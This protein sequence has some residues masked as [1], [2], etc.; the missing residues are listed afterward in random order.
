MNVLPPQ[1]S[2]LLPKEYSCLMN[3]K[4]SPIIYYYPISIKLD[5]YHHTFYHEC[6]PKLPNINMKLLQQIVDKI[7]KK[8]EINKIGVIWNKNSSPYVSSDS[9]KIPVN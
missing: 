8:Y 3:E 4:N 6:E 2:H 7:K 1:S 5:K 9:L